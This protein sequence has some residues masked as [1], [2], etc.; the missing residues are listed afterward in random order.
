MFVPFFDTRHR[1]SSNYHKAYIG[2]K[3]PDINILVYGVLFSKIQV[4]TALLI[5]LTHLL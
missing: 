4:V 2:P 3:H 1:T 5:R